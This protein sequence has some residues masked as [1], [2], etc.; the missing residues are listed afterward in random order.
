MLASAFNQSMREYLT[1]KIK[2]VLVKPQKLDELK[3]KLLAS[4]RLPPLFPRADE[5]AQCTKGEVNKFF[6]S[7]EGPTVKNINKFINY[8]EANFDSIK[9]DMII[10]SSPHNTSQASS[11]RGDIE[12]PMREMDIFS[13]TSSQASDMVMSS[14]HSYTDINEME[15]TDI[16][17]ETEISSQLSELSQ[18]TIQT[19]DDP[20]HYGERRTITVPFSS[21]I[22]KALEKDMKDEVYK[23]LDENMRKATD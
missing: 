22:H 1:R 14:Q 7:P 6:D 16:I 4:T 19:Q 15:S 12:S 2:P 5:I 23:K 17:S 10:S 3:A 11:S 13:A 20:E 8:I 18:S 21:I 9:D